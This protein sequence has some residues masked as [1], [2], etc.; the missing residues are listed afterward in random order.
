VAGERRRANSPCAAADH[1][2][3]D[4]DPA[5]EGAPAAPKRSALSPSENSGAATRTALP[6]WRVAA[7]P[8]GLE[9]AANEGARLAV[10]A[11]AAVPRASRPDLEFIV[12]HGARRPAAAHESLKLRE[13]L[14]E[15]TA[16]QSTR[17]R[18]FSR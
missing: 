4:Q 18:I 11:H 3:L 9:N 5:V 7:P 1:P 6:A 17:R 12:S 16:G 10:R 15:A 13:K 14:K 2:R 8:R